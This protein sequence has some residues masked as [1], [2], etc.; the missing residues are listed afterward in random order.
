MVNGKRKGNNYEREISK[1]LSLWISNNKSDDLFWRSQGSGGR[2]TVRYKK[3]LTLEGQSG[4]IASTHSGIS[5]DFLKIFCVEVKFYK[6]INIWGMITKT[7]K[8]ILDFWEQA[9]KK[10]RQVKKLPILIVKENYRPAL[11]ISNRAFSMLTKKLKLRP[12]LEVNLSYQKLFI[13][14]FKDILDV[15]FDEFMSIIRE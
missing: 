6:D 1:N 2:H 8:G 13:W 7:K 14:K 5:E 12:E 3:N 10:A 9:Y 11:F 15:N 4:D